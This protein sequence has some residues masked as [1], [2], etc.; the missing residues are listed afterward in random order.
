MQDITDHLVELVKSASTDLSPDVE[1]TLEAACKQEKAG[2]AAQGAMQ[3]ILENVRMSRETARPIC[4]DTGTPIFYVWYPEGSSQRTMRE[5]I[6]AAVRTATERAYLR[7]NAVEALSGKNSGDNTGV[8]FPAIHFE[9][10]ENDYL[11]IG[12]LLKGGGSENCGCTYSVP[13]P[14]FPASRDIKGVRKAVLDAAFKAQ[15]LGCA[16]GLLG[17]GIGGD[18]GSSMIKAKEQLF[19]PVGDH[20][21]DAELD[22][23]EKQLHRE[24]NE[25][26]IGPM[27]FGGKTTV[28]GVK[29]AQ[30]HRVPACFFVSIAYMCWAD[31]RKIMTIKNGSVEIKAP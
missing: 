18:R 23:M 20:N 17:V 1:Q 26:G 29:M 7:P 4:Q 3:T 27:G 19:R 24:I 16:P 25:L 8:D 2:S 28:F 22:A 21:P 30:L 13:S 31:R 15:G 10:W 5:Q 14:E 6:H 11:K 12:L 9:E